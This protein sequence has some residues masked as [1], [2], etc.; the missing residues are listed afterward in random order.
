MSDGLAAAGLSL[1]GGGGRFVTP[2]ETNL[3]GGALCFMAKTW[4]R[5]ETTGSWW[6]VAVGGWWLLAVGGWW[7]VAVGGWWLVAVG[8]WWLLAVTGWWR[9]AVGGGRWAV[10]GWWPLAVPR[11]C[12]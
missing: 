9:W 4:A 1:K 11:G 6:L 3:H 8:G 5:H 12:P 7:L 2:P 10:G